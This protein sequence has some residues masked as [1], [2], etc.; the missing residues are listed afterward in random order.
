MK[1]KKRLIFT[2]CFI[3]LSNIMLIKA[4][5]ESNLDYNEFNYQYLASAH[6][7]HTS[8]RANV[9]GTYVQPNRVINYDIKI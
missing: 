9:I 4:N 8:S 2:V 3:L 1:I 6:Y 7:P 5:E